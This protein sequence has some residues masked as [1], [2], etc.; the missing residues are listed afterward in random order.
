MATVF[1]CQ[2]LKIHKDDFWTVMRNYAA[3]SKDGLAPD[4][5]DIANSMREHEYVNP[6]LLTSLCD[7]PNRV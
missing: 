7:C 1:D 4:L 6:I 2:L 5:E 3:R